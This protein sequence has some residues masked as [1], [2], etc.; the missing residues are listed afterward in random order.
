MAKEYSRSDIQGLH[1]IDPET[2][3]DRVFGE[4]HTVTLKHILMSDIPPHQRIA[5]AVSLLPSDERARAIQLC[6][7]ACQRIIR[8]RDA[9][10]EMQAF[11][12]AAML[13]D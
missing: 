9:E 4:Q 3:L 2:L 11:A 13:E 1:H 5:V 6:Y 8:G 7:D 10:G 12:I